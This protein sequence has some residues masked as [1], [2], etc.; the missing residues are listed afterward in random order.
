MS[1]L[2]MGVE[3]GVH[4]IIVSVCL[5]AHAHVREREKK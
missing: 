1:M 2:Y 5:S 4:K 3:L